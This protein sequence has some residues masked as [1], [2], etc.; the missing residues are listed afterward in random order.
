M[1]QIKSFLC[2]KVPSVFVSEKLEVDKL[3]TRFVRLTKLMILI[4]LLLV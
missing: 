3:G 1:T 2:W 4:I